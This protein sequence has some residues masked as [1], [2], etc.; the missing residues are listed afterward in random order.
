MFAS[1][2]AGHPPPTT[3][4]QPLGEH[5]SCTGQPCCPAVSVQCAATPLPYNAIAAIAPL[6]ALGTRWF[7]QMQEDRVV[8]SSV[9][10]SHRHDHHRQPHRH[11]HH[12]HQQLVL[13]EVRMVR[14]AAAPWHRH[15][16][17]WMVQEVLR[18]RPQLLPAGTPRAF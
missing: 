7:V 1:C 14:S 13:Q 15:Q 5:T 6:T 18:R 12:R 8:R 2:P 3:P 4:G 10:R 17:E 11:H 9:A 16:Q